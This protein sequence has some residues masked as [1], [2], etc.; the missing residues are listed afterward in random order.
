MRFRAE[1]RSSL[2]ALTTS[3][4]SRRIGASPAKAHEGWREV[5]ASCVSHASGA[6]EVRPSHLRAC[7]PGGG[8]PR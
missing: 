7:G 8:Q 4:S 2:R 1:A 5:A 3:P 6:V